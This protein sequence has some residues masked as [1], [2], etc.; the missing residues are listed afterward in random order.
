MGC[1]VGVCRLLH[2]CVSVYVCLCVYVC[3]CVCLRVRVSV[4]G[5]GFFCLTNAPWAFT[6]IFQS[7]QM[8]SNSIPRARASPSLSHPTFL[9]FFAFSHIYTNPYCPTHSLTIRHQGLFPLLLHI[10]NRSSLLERLSLT[11]PPPHPQDEGSEVRCAAA[12]GLHST[13]PGP[14]PGAGAESR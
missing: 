12:H 5:K 11:Y 9:F 8:F 10:V 13:R 1:P 7:V 14:E 6:T 3:G 4:R 2:Y